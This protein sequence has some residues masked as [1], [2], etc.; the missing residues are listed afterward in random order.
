V[1]GRRFGGVG[2]AFRSKRTQEMA[3]VMVSLAWP[4]WPVIWGQWSVLAVAL[5]ARERAG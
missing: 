1:V 2:G 4:M 5:Y 3:D